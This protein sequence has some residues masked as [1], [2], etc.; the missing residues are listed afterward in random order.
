MSDYKVAINR[1]R[2]L[3]E[4]GEALREVVETLDRLGSL[5]NAVSE[6]QTRLEHLRMD[7]V[8]AKDQLEKVKVE[9]EK[10]GQYAR[11]V[12]AKAEREADDVANNASLR[13]RRLVSD[14]KEE[15]AKLTQDAQNQVD[16]LRKE[17]SDLRTDKEK[18][19]KEYLELSEKVAA[20]RKTI[21]DM[22]NV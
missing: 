7:E 16:V 14:A 21:S 1:I 22:V 12:K 20:L 10:A 11:D 2:K 4:E 13:Y 3:A 18:A 8:R 5:E 9:V 6:S 17:F 19:T 15:A